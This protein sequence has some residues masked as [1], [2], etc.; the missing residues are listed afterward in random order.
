MYKKA[1][2]VATSILFLSACSSNMV[3]QHQIHSISANKNSEEI[4]S[5]FDQAQTTGVGD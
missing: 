2:I 5:L 1:L 3:K 4:K